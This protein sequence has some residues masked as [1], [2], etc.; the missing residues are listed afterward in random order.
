MGFA[1]VK[2]INDDCSL[3]NHD[4]CDSYQQELETIEQIKRSYP[5]NIGVK[6]FDLG[7]FSTLAPDLKAR[8]IACVRSGVENPTSIMGA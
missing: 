7:Y 2:Y 5:E 6:C 4:F 8:M 1:F 3:D